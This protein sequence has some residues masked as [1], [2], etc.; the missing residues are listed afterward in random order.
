M[1]KPG[2]RVPTSGIYEIV[3]AHGSPAVE[4]KTI[5]LD[6]DRVFPPTPE[7]GLSYRLKQEVVTIYTTTSSNI[8]MTGTSTLY[9]DVLKRLAKK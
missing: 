3:P 7:A 9:S 2:E 1:Y 4:A 5:A 6:K 8:T